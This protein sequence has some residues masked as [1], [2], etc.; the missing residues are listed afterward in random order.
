M[1][2]LVAA[3]ESMLAASIVYAYK[4]GLS[5]A[6]YEEPEI[7]SSWAVVLWIN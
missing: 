3:L 1:Y 5:S 4:E 2:I 7:F 6:H